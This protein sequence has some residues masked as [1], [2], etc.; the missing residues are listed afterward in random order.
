[1]KIVH[2]FTL[3]CS[4]ILLPLSHSWAGD[5]LDRIAKTNTLRVGM[6][7]AAAPFNFHNRDGEL[8]GMEVELAKLLAKAMGVELKI[9]E[10][11]FG[12]LLPALEKGDVELVMSLVTATL[13]RNRRVAFVGPYYVSGKSMLTTSETVAGIRETGE[14]NQASMRI[15]AMKGSTSEAFVH[16]NVPKAKLV[17]TR[18]YDEAVKKLLDGEVDAML[19]DAPVIKLTMMR[20]PNSGLAMLDKPL[21]IEPIGIAVSP[22]DVLLLN[23]MQNY[24]QALRSTGGLEALHKKWF[25]DAGWLTQLP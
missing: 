7:G 9:V 15:V 21:T 16:R 22:D 23:L 3:L 8:V 1:M 14:V 12:D 25:E 11:P 5:V 13:E 20:H 4:L 18:D 17:T 19:A 10:M 2:R 6:T 24:M